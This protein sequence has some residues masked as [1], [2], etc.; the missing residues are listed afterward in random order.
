MKFKILPLVLLVLLFACKEED[1]TPKDP[2]EGT[3]KITSIK[4]IEADNKETD[5]WVFAKFLY[6]CVADI[7]YTFS[8]GS[9][10]T[11][12]PNGCTVEESQDLGAIGALFQE[13]SGSYT[14]AESVFSVNINGN[15]LPG[16]ITFSGNTATVVTVD[17]SDL[18][19]TISITFT[20]V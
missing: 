8:N 6:P 17:P 12:V 20:K 18:T 15:Q 3:W 4:R 7:T 16:N 5:F 1:T 14:L 10:S 2:I 19:T 13:S 11:S 9:Y